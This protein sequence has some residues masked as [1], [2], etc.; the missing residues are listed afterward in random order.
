MSC[1]SCD[2]RNSN[3]HA[4]EPKVKTTKKAKKTTPNKTVA[5]PTVT[6]NKQLQ[7]IEVKSDKM[8]RNITNLVVLPEQYFID[9]SSTYPVLYLLHGYSDDY[10]AWQNHVDLTK[11]ANKY[12]FIIVCPDGQDSWY[13]DSPIDPTFQFE[14]YITQELRNYIESNYRTINDRQHRA[15]TGLSMGGHGALWLGFRHPDLYGLCGSMSGAVDITT[16][17]DRFKIDKRLGKYAAN[18]ASWKSHS[19][20]NLVPTLKNDQ[21]IIIDDGT[22]DFLIKENR[23][24]HDALQQHKI[25]HEYSER[26]GRHSWDYWL[27]SLEQHLAAFDNIM[28]TKE[29]D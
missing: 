1:I 27:K 28:N 17:K 13:F 16:L 10:M 21:F 5:Q 22:S 7:V 29:G 19:V 3:S 4:T 2:A 25:K 24:L 11:H 14:T 18:E 26:P 8:G 23:A 9:S 12:G 20:I 15:I 6:N